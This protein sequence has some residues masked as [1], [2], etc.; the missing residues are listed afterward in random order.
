MAGY[1]SVTI[2]YENGELQDL[3]C[4]AAAVSKGLFLE[5]GGFPPCAFAAPDSL[6]MSILLTYFPG[7]IVQVAKGQPL[8]FVRQHAYQDT[9]RQFGRFYE[10]ASQIRDIA[11]REWPNN[12]FGWTKR[13]QR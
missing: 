11:T 10:P 6:F 4:N 1:Y 13:V 12:D 5:T 3:P 7:R 2:Q 9:P 8:Y